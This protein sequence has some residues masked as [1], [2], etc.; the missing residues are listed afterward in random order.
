MDAEIE[1]IPVDESTEI[2]Q[3]QYCCNVCQYSTIYRHNL[4]RHTKAKHPSKESTSESTLPAIMF[5]HMC[6]HCGKK[7]RSKFGLSTHIKSVHENTYRFKCDTCQR[8]FQGLWNFRGHLR[9]HHTELKEKCKQ[10][11]KT[12][13][14]RSSLQRHELEH[15]NGNSTSDVSKLSCSVCGVQC[16]NAKNLSDHKRGLHGG[17]LYMCK[18]C[19]KTFRWRSSL[20]YHE[21][22]VDHAQGD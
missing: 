6:H 15:K 19:G 3:T 7:Y 12:F 5:E 21:K 17:K 16:T 8:G 11:S 4:T 10:C 1:I 14:Y 13:N 9:S 22:H 20:S 18:V 2:V